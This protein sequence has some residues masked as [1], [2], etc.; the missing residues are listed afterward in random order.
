MINKY[1]KKN[2]EVLNNTINK[3]NCFIKLGK[4]VSSKEEKTNVYR[5]QCNECDVAYVGQTERRLSIRVN[6]H[7]Q[8]SENNDLGSAIYTHMEDFDHNFNFNKVKILHT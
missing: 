2:T 5:I 4:D 3:W 6:E 1:I 8:K 7:I